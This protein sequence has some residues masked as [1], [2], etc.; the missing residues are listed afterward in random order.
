M[1][2]KTS[3]AVKRKAGTADA[4]AQFEN[5]RV[6]FE[7]RDGTIVGVEDVSFHINPGE[8]VCV[9]GETG[10]GKSVS[11][12]SMMRLVEFGGGRVAG[13][14]LIFDRAEGGKINVADADQSL[15][16]S[17]RGNEIGMIFQEP[18]TALNPVFTVGRQLTEGL[19]VHKGMN[20]AEARQTALELLE[21]VRIP[22][23]EKRLD[24]YPH[25]LS[26][27]MRQRVVIAMALACE[28]RLLI[29]DEPTTALDVTIQAEI[30]ALIDRLKQETGTA[31]LFITHDM[32]VVAQV[33]D[34]VVVMFRGNKVEEGPVEQIFK[35]PQHAYTQSLLAAVPK[36]GEMK[37]TIY[38]ERM[39]LMTD[40]KSEPEPITGSQ[41]VLLEVR[42]L[43]TRF[44]M[45]GGLMRRVTANVHAVEDVSF[46]LMKGRT[47]SLVGESGCGKSTVGRSLLRLIE[48][49]AGSVKINGVDVLAMQKQEL[50]DTRRHM[51]MVFQDPFASL[52]PQMRLIDQVAEPMQNYKTLDA[53]EINRRVEML[54]DRVK[55]PRS[56]LRRYPHELSGGQRQRVAIARALALNPELII[57]DEAVSALDVSVQAEVLNLMMELQVEL[58]LS[59]LFISHDMAV[60]E[61]VSHDVGVMYLGRLVE[62]GP[63]HKVFEN[64]QHAYTKALMSAVPIADPT[65][66]KGEAEL[67]FKAINSPVRPIGYEAEPSVYAKISDGHFVL[68][69]DSGY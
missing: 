51:Q 5:L 69:T 65:Q 30:L 18:M 1:P 48:P 7:T 42:N 66:R 33:A 62:I 55:L 64:P 24:Q 15:M 10:S 35:N 13:G 68:Q 61:R 46:T 3:T 19:R 25:E 60:V 22:E 43:V 9:V 4:I 34:R 38:P 67:N 11:S 39:R 58:G 45:K 12:L 23:A 27:G 20:K 16:R 8:T 26:G 36:L 29:A 59:Y 32:A 54:F 41:D 52:D 21:K 53:D 6:E 47:L 57:A 44:P 37:G 28:P 56:F 2:S 31:V 40:G 63:R 49:H 17:I 50:H 14:K